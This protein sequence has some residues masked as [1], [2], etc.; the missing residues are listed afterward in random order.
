MSLLRELV[1]KEEVTMAAR[2]TEEFFWLLHNMIGHPMM[3][4]L[5]SFGFRE[6]ADRV[7]DCTIPPA[8]RGTGRG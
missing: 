3:F 4:V 1:F 8:V 5:A 7:H 6:L 2:W